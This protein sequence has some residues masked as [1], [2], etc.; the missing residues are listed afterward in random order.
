MIIK[1]TCLLTDLPTYLPTNQSAYLLYQRLQDS[2]FPIA[3]T[4]Y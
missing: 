3:P 4:T 1:F 2:L